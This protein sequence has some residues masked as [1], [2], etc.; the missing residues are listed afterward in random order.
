M[1][2]A[3][4]IVPRVGV[5]SNYLRWG[6]LE[7]LEHCSIS[8]YALRGIGTAHTL[9]RFY[10]ADIACTLISVSRF[11]YAGTCLP[12]LSGFGTAHTLS[13]LSV[14]GPSQYPRYFSRQ[15]SN[16]LNIR[17]TSCSRAYICAA[18]LCYPDHQEKN[19]LAGY[20]LYALKLTQLATKYYSATS[21]L[22]SLFVLMFTPNALN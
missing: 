16:T 13:L 9:S 17:T 2:F 11:G 19:I 10:P 1:N 8:I 7:Y 20:T 6:Q 12:V 14:F 22:R 15:Y 21:T 5:G 3:N 4:T 18:F